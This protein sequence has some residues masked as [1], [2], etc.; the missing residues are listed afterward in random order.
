MSG[1]TQCL[2]LPL[3]VALGGTGVITATGTPGSTVLSVSPALTGTPTA[4]TAAFGTSTTQIATTAFVQGAIPGA[5]ILRNYIAGLTLSTAGSSATFGVAA[6]QATDSTNVANMTLSSAYTKTTSAWALGTGNG[7]LDT[8]AIANNTWYSVYE[9]TRV[10][11]GVVDILTSLSAT[12]PTLPTNY[13][14]FRRIGSML[15][16]GSAQWTAF[17]QNGNQFLWTGGPVLDQNPATVGATASTLTLASIPTGVKV[18]VLFNSTINNIT[19]ASDVYFSSLDT[20]DVALGLGTRQLSMS[21]MS[22]STAGS[23]NVLSN[24]SGQIRARADAASTSV[25]IGTAGWIDL[26]GQI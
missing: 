22:V 2:Q 21:A 26:R 5:S 10:D 3:P 15:I 8:G 6:G 23:F 17:T 12:T 14:L 11:T 25:F 16:N 1:L 4:P 13:T 18:N 7:S 24:S 9:I 20:N 19:S